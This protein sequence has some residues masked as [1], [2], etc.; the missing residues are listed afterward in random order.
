MYW[1]NSITFGVCS[2]A[3]LF[4]LPPQEPSVKDPRPRNNQRRSYSASPRFFN[5]VLLSVS[6]LLPTTDNRVLQTAQVTSAVSGRR[7]KGF[8]SQ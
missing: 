4:L 6:G 5:Q 1:Y 7:T 3:R 8:L 2:V